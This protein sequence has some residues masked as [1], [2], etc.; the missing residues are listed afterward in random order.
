MTVQAQQTASPPAI[1]APLRRRRFDAEVGV[2]GGP[3]ALADAVGLL[4]DLMAGAGQQQVAAEVQAHPL[5]LD[6]AG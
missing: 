1:P 5:I 2:E 3:E 6:L 4:Q